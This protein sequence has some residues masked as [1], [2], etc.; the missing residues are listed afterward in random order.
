M[1]TPASG[2]GHRGSALEIAERE[3]L[4]YRVGMKK[5]N[6][7][8]LAVRRETIRALASAELARAAGGDPVMLLDSGK[9]M[10]PSLAVPKLP[11]G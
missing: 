5:P 10:C 3:T 11:L 2:P 7:T 1:D 6:P 8:K 4:H 9:E